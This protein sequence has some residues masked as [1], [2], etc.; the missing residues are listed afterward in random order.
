M[1]SLRISRTAC[2]LMAFLQTARLAVGVE[3]T[4]AALAALI[5]SVIGAAMFDYE[6]FA[7]NKRMEAGIEEDD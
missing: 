3:D 1:R 7:M 6:I 5:A 4:A 2:V